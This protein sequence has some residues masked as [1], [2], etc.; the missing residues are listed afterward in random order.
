[1]RF[2]L[3]GEPVAVDLAN[4]IVRERGVDIDLLSDRAGI[5]EWLELHSGQLPSGPVDGEA[6]LELRGALRELLEDVDAGRPVSA[7]AAA[8]INRAAVAAPVPQ[9]RAGDGAALLSWERGGTEATLAAIA[10]NMLQVL[11]AGSRLRTCENH[12]CLLHFVA[13]DSRRRF[14][15]TARCSN[16][17][18]QAR[19][20]GR[21]AAS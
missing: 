2:P 12:D 20:R 10:Q 13:Y 3:I 11:A 1:M 16:R 17:A 4:T 8:E 21:Q 19:H 18:R 7:A 9:L 15:A 6:L 14:C 5:D